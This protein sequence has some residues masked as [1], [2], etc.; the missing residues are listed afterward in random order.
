M[1]PTRASHRSSDLSASG[2]ARQTG[3]PQG[4]APRQKRR[5]DPPSQGRD[6]FRAEP[7]S[8]RDPGQS[9]G[10]LAPTPRSRSVGGR[11]K[12]VAPSRLGM[13]T[14]RPTARQE[15]A[16]G[17]EAMGARRV[18]SAAAPL[19]AEAPTRRSRPQQGPGR[20]RAASRGFPA[21]DRRNAARGGAS[22]P[23]PNRSAKDR[24]STFSQIGRA[25]V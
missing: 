6:R 24:A 14:S 13:G 12:P 20:S 9:P 4:Q 7:S 5:G 8:G 15:P 23:N 21:Q 25:H 1:K 11:L 3:R 18:V 22:P 19:P 17:R 10:T 16:L 2:Q